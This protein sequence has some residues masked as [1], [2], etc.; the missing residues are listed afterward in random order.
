[1]KKNL[2]LLIRGRLYNT[3]CV[4]D[5]HYSS[6]FFQAGNMVWL[7]RQGEAG[8]QCKKKK[9][10]KKK[11]TNSMSVPLASGERVQLLEGKKKDEQKSEHISRRTTPEREGT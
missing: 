8:F 7:E 11:R 5:S 2:A 1:M 10:K 4:F 3:L 9:K 6:V